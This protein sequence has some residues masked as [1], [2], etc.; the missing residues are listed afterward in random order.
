[1]FS[2][3]CLIITITVINTGVRFL[4]SLGQFFFQVPKLFIN[5]FKIK[6]GFLNYENL[7]KEY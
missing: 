1:M 7:S 2:D 5:I 6:E 3:K 4:N